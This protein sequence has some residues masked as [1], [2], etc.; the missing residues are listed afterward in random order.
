MPDRPVRKVSIFVSSPTD[1]MSERERAALVIDRLQSRFRE[2]VTIAPVFFE[3]KEIYYTADKSFQDQIPDAGACDLVVSIFWGRLGSELAPDQFGT[4]PD[5]KP[6]PGGA[7]YELMRALAAKRRNE[8]PD[9]LVYRKTADTG[10]SVT[11]PHQRR[12]MTAQLDAFEV[13]WKQWFVSEEGHFRA[14]FQSF[15]RPDEFEQLL[16]GHLRAW[17]DEHGLLGKEVIWRVA[18]RGSPYRGLEPYEPEHA[19]VFFGREREIDR[20]RQRL[21]AAAATGTGFLLIMGPSGAGKSS[22]AR[23]GLITRLTQPGDIEGIDV[24]RYAVMRPGD[25]A[26]P[27]RALAEA[28]FRKDALPEL[29]QGDSPAPELL[30]TTLAAD[31]NSAA[32]PILGAL[33]RLAENVKAEKSYDH[34]VEPRLLIVIDQLEELFSTNV[35]AAERTA[36]V[37]LIA[38]LARSGRVYV[39]A[40]LRSSAYGALAREAELVALKDSGATLDV[41]VPGP[42]VLAEIVRSPATAAGLNFERRADKNLDEELLAAAGGNAD[43]L[44]LLG[45]T[46]EW[47]F[48]HRDGERLT[49]AAYDQLGGLDGAIGRAAEQTFQNLDQDAQA[50]LPQ[51]LRGLAET[52]RRAAGLALRDLPLTDTP[53]GTP[54]RRLADALI[55]ARVLLVYGEGQGAM[56][57]LAHDAV[58]RGWQRARD[59]TTKEQDFYRIREDVT[60]AQQRWR[61]KQRNDLLLAPGLLLAEA[62]SLW[63]TYG[64]ELGAD[65]VTFINASVRQEQRRRRRGYAL[66]AVFGLVAIGAMAAGVI[67]WSAADRA[68][69]NF[70]TA[71]S[72]NDAIIRD[73][74]DGLKDAEGMRVDTLRRMLDVADAAVTKL[75]SSNENDP[76]ALMQ[77][78]LVLSRLSDVYLKIGSTEIAADYARKALDTIRAAAPKNPDNTVWLRNKSLILE[79]VAD[80][81]ST[82]G[83]LAGALTDYRELIVIAR[84]RIAKE[85]DS[86]AWQSDMYRVLDKIGDVLGTQ[87]DLASALTTYRETLEIARALTVTDLNN[88]E[89]QRYVLRA[90]DKIDDVLQTQNDQAATLTKYSKMLSITQELAAKDP[91]NMERQ[92]DVSVILEQIGSALR[93]Q[94]DPAGALTNYR[95]CLNIL[96]SLVAKDPSN[97]QRQRDVSVILGK[98][99][100]V[101]ATQGDS[102]GALTNY[103]DSLNILNSLVAKDP[104]NTE[105]Q[106]NLW[107][108]LENI[109]DMLATQGDAAGAL[110]NYGDSL[111]IIKAL[112]TKDPGNTEWQSNLSVNLG[113]IGEVLQTQ[114]DPAGA[115]TN[116]RDSLKIRNVLAAKDTG[117]TAWQVDVSLSL[118][119]IGDVLATQGDLTGAL[120][121]YRDGLKIRSALATKTP[122]NTAWQHNVSVSLEKIGDVL[123]TQGDSAD[124]LTNYRDSLKIRDALAAQDPGNTVW[125]N[126][127]S[128][129]LERVG[130]VLQA[131]GDRAGALTNYRDSLKILKA[132]VA[133]DPGNT[134]WQNNLSANLERV[135]DVLATQGERAD[136]LTNYRDSLKIRNALAAQ[137][138]GNT[139]WQNDVSVSLERVGDVLQAQGDLAGALTN[140]RDSLKICNALVAKNPG[141]NEW[142]RDV[143]RVLSKT[144]KILRTQNDEVAALAS[145]RE[146]LEVARTLAVKDPANTLWQ[147]YASLALESTGD[148]LETQGEHASALINYREMI[149]IDRALAD[150]DPSNLE[151]QRKLLGALNK[152][153]PLEIQG[154]SAN[155]LADYREMLKLARALSDKDPGNTQWRGLVAAALELVGNML[156]IQ[157]DNMGALAALWESLAI[158]R[159]LADKE[160][161]NPELQNDV[162]GDVET[163]GDIAHQLNLAHDFSTALEAADQ[164]IAIAPDQLRVQDSRADALMFL[165]RIDE[166]RAIYLKYRGQKDARS[167]TTWEQMVRQDFA[168]LRKAGLTHPL[169][170]E[171]ERQLGAP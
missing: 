57:R 141:N 145:Y 134:A 33:K 67:A 63:A 88:T 148:V 29:A 74:V 81:L 104:G 47:L 133:K 110:T 139:T 131:Q 125:Q 62:Q 10:I 8:L 39:I 83:D 97:T 168:E 170:V 61:E 60:A 157:G 115:L 160:P 45:F 16:E 35:P 126:N 1:V 94:G 123:A 5:G 11:D 4:L 129:S 152:V 144:G 58:L 103:R 111:K 42:E 20:G 65:L 122:G 107:M 14:G 36:F 23:A 114:G 167:K 79:R 31:A 166:A 24:V 41:G 146:M 118:E 72:T 112:A 18:E 165:A 116:Y 73:L 70:E 15:K 50:A 13:F 87:G 91:G 159:A 68:D 84:A 49:F 25:A 92:R 158:N 34:P 43:A 136:A 2:H 86:R 155:A 69:R 132:L 117:N 121:H 78:A 106:T 40:T 28:L 48:E 108:N 130:D 21:L 124:A 12:L 80:L 161:V 98:I 162:L 120:T 128:L 59:I 27:Q 153:G 102:A 46:L 9:I 100:D 105:W 76:K 26:T 143:L 37:Q 54:R 7:V 154:D 140:Y 30:A 96:S 75:A 89:W 156:E 19:E 137:D 51:L 66:A 32:L 127:M 64:T 44:P 138:P 85:P 109:G 135:G 99:G 6:Y 142:Q 113:K 163:I 93:A 53:E 119:K 38:A 82:Q 101:L 90:Q 3:D 17:L 164:A 147:N 171:I 52:S 95:D 77:R 55:A 22:L 149:N 151:R 56:L 71:M 150:K 169:M